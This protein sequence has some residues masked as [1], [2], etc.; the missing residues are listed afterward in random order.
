MT[1]TSN[2]RPEQS[3]GTAEDSGQAA[4]N[5]SEVPTEDKPERFLGDTSN[6][7]MTEV[8][9]ESSPESDARS[10]AGSGDGSEAGDRSGAGSGSASGSDAGSDGA[11]PPPADFDPA[12]N[13]SNEELVA[14]EN[15]E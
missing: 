7:G 4:G 9:G 13:P 15:P 5:P 8:T 3:A 11:T 12:D 6:D 1:H 2:H 10:G 14:G